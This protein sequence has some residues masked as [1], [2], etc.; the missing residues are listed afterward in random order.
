MKN[1]NDVKVVGNLVKDPE[2]HYTTKGTPVANVPIGVNET[3]TV[4]NEKHQ[5][6]TFVDVQVWG[7]PAENLAKLAKKGEEIF[8]EGALRQDLWEDKETGKNRSK[9]F[10]KAE[11]WQLTQYKASEEHRRESAR[12]QEQPSI[13]R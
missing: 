9:L 7:A 2:V 10:L 1:I 8:V 5:I 13:Q 4:D 3:Y 12:A 6:T 11:R